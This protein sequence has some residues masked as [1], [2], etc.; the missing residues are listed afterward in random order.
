MLDFLGR[1]FCSVF[2]WATQPIARSTRIALVCIVFC[3]SCRT[4]QRLTTKPH[5]SDLAKIGEGR[6]DSPTT[7][8]FESG[9]AVAVGWQWTVGGFKFPVCLLSQKKSPYQCRGC[10]QRLTH[11]RDPQRNGSWVTKAMVPPNRKL[12]NN[13]V[14]HKLEITHN[15]RQTPE[16][17]KRKRNHGHNWRSSVNEDDQQETS[18]GKKTSATNSL[19]KYTCGRSTHRTK[20]H[21]VRNII[22]ERLPW[23]FTCGCSTAERKKGCI[24]SV[25][26]CLPVS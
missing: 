25:E 17:K 22:S 8:I 14:A 26:T 19:E 13:S 15:N 3:V 12:N 23:K 7:W 11:V 1:Q 5:L 21:G 16:R 6:E 4:Q 20:R 2:S 10:S 24:G 9:C 18:R